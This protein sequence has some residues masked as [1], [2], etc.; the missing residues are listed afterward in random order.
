ME[1]RKLVKIQKEVAYN[2]FHCKISKT[3]EHLGFKVDLYVLL[4]I[5]DSLNLS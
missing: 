5:T 3:E 4:T 1:R 2:K